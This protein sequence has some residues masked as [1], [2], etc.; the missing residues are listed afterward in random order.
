MENQNLTS[1]I[2]GNYE[3]LKVLG[4]GCFGQVFKCHKKD[5]KETVAVK[6]LKRNHAENDKIREVS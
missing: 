3:V 1:A 2:P 5:T 4:Q 6:V